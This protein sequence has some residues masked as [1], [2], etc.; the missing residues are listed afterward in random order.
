MFADRLGDIKPDRARIQNAAGQGVEEE[1]EGGG[2]G[3]S[4]SG[5]GGSIEKDRCKRLSVGGRRKRETEN[6]EKQK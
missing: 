1:E 5:G 2:G 4:S 3:G 6:E